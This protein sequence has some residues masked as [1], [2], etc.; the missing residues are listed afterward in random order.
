M[1]NQTG[2]IDLSHSP[3]RPRTVQTKANIS[4]VKY[5]LAQKKQI[6]SRRLAAEINIS[7]TSARRI[8]HGVYN[9]QNDRVWAISRAK[10]DRQGAIHQKTKFPTKVMVW[11]GVCAQGLTEL[12]IIEHGT[13]NA[14]RY[15]N[16]VLHIAL[17]SGNRMLGDDWTC[18]QDGAKPHIHKMVQKWCA[19]HFPSFISKDRWPP[20]S[21][22]LCPLDYS[23]W[24]EL[25]GSMDWH[26]ITTKEIL[27]NEIKFS[28]KKLKKRKFYIQYTILL[29]DCAK[30]RKTE[31]TIF[32]K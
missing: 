32:V 7:R 24:N 1:L 2:S 16:E 31:E 28:V 10:A 23:L 5:R 26:K 29:Y 14:E 30:S 15:I 3:G 9:V 21:P 27:I 17:R 25:A 12:V 6:S 8:L 11:L 19:D 20:N 22:D 18:Q 4:K 13:M